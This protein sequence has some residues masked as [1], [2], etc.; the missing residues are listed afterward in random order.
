MGEG[1]VLLIPHTVTLPASNHLIAGHVI[2][3]KDCPAL[4]TRVCN[5]FSNWGDKWHDWFPCAGAAASRRQ[6]PFSWSCGQRCRSQADQPLANV[7]L[8]PLRNKSSTLLVS[9]LTCCLSVVHTVL[10]TR[11]LTVLHHPGLFLSLCLR[12]PHLCLYLLLLFLDLVSQGT[13]S[14][15]PSM[16][17]FI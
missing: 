14:K 9:D 11:L 2:G 5:Y 6:G 8:P 15:K 1:I 12:L 3:R 17:T 16:N 13:S 4:Y 10:Y 7:H